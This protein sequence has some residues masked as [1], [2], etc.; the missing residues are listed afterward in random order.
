MKYFGYFSFLLLA[1]SGCSASGDTPM[2]TASIVGN[3]RVTKA[4][5]TTM[6]KNGGAAY[7]ALDPNPSGVISFAANGYET[8]YIGNAPYQVP[9]TYTPPILTFQY[10]AGPSVFT[11]TK[12]TADSL[13]M[14]SQ[15]EDAQN[16]YNDAYSY[17]KQP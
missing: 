5:H 3:W 16:K 11:V 8:Y 13:S 9:Y 6:P 1:M 7:S 14:H 4:V 10:T 15:R 12:L 17:A 2:P